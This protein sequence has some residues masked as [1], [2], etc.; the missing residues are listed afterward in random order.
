MSAE[1]TP[2]DFKEKVRSIGVMRRTEAARREP[3]LD[4]D[5]SAYQRLR[6]E[7]IQP[8]TLTGAAE[9]ERTMDHRHEAEMGHAFPADRFP[10]RAETWRK[11]DEGMERGREME[12][13]R[14]AN[15]A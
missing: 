3:Q 6:A 13:W 4:K 12:E 11:V 14:A 8:R 5:R 7:G 9:L 2:V 15:G 1:Q 10:N